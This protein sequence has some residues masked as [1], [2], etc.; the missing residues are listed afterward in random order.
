MIKSEVYIG[1]VYWLERSAEWHERAMEDIEA[2]G[3]LGLFP[4]DYDDLIWGDDWDDA[5][6][7]SNAGPPYGAELVKLEKGDIVIVIKGLKG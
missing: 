7:E 3:E 6:A 2:L 4:L 5:P 1:R